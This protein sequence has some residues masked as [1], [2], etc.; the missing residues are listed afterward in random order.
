MPRNITIYIQNYAYVGLTKD[1]RAMCHQQ[2]EFSARW[3]RSLPTG[4]HFRILNNSLKSLDR[5]RVE[6]GDEIVGR[7]QEWHRTGCGNGA[8]RVLTFETLMNELT[9]AGVEAVSMGHAYGYQSAEP[10]K[11]R[12][13]ECEEEPRGDREVDEISREDDGGQDAEDD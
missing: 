3:D 8:E 6:R 9:Q 7:L 10:E 12:E 5:F 1:M 11:D 2:P 13:E 4:C